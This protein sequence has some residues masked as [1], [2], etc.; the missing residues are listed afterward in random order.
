M[1]GLWRMQWSQFGTPGVGSVI[2]RMCHLCLGWQCSIVPC[3]SPITHA[4]STDQLHDGGT[5][6]LG[7]F[8]Q[9]TSRSLRQHTLWKV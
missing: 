9:C 3:D 2:G 6:I 4:V 8:L 5:C 1:F 7:H